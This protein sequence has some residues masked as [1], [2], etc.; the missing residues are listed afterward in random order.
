MT[1]GSGLSRDK[2]I[3][4]TVCVVCIGVAA[5]SMIAYFVGGDYEPPAAP[6]QCLAC[7]QTFDIDKAEELSV[8]CPEC[9]EPAIRLVYSRCPRCRK[10]V[11]TSR[12]H[13]TDAGR[14]S[15][16]QINAELSGRAARGLT[17]LRLL[18]L[19][20]VFQ[21][22]LGKPGGGYEWSDWIPDKAPERMELEVS[23]KC[24]ECGARLR[25]N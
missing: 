2:L 23:L 15:Y 7:E 17:K 8:S 21:Y 9:G 16:A 11:L 6:W 20:K 18:D 13:L 25:S 24:P 1:F 5:V 3:S 19:P 12:F 10:D 14:E 22:R 4:V